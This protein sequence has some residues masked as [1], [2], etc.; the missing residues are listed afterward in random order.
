MNKNLTRRSLVCTST[1]GLLGFTALSQAQ[2]AL[3]ALTASPQPH[4]DLRF[5]T[6]LFHLDLKSGKVVWASTL[7]AADRDTA[8]V[9]YSFENRTLVAAQQSLPGEI[10]VLQF[11]SPQRPAKITVDL[12]GMSVVGRHFVKLDGRL[13]LVLQLV[14]GR[15]RFIAVNLHDLQAR[16]VAPAEAY[17]EF[18][19][20][21]F[22]GGLVA[23][24]DFAFFELT[25]RP[26]RLVVAETMPRLPYPVKVPVD[27]ALPRD[28]AFGLYVSN[29][30]ILA[31]RSGRALP[32]KGPRGTA[33]YHVC[34]RSTNEWHSI[35]V[36]GGASL[37]RGFGPWLA[38]Q[39][40]DILDDY[41]A[42]PGSGIRRDKLSP[43][44]PPF[45][46]MTSIFRLYMPGLIY[47]YHVPT[48]RRIIEE[49]GQGDT[50]V[51][52]VEDEHVLY[53]CDQI[54]YEAR[55]EGTRLAGHR[56]LI[57][58]DFIR[59]VHWVFYGPPAPP[60]PDPP[61]PPFKAY[62]QPQ[63]GSDGHLP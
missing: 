17:R 8:F 7:I 30:E 55:I 16:E 44:G 33:L 41:V 59:D 28:E 12:G 14:D 37:A 21:G 53:R 6:V 60:P 13:H 11:A 57:E 48:R 9:L 39:V 5:P 51:L 4:G 50:E 35:S 18:A 15:Y 47:L 52:W 63:P 49:T 29:G 45:D 34:N 10:V 38:V 56:K 27:V 46:L 36:P 1:A 26:H 20:D 31:F 62:G 54:L 3:Y 22:V 43:T 40:R 61:Y 58:Q 23:N 24:N 2:R 32:T 19:I 25:S 42:S